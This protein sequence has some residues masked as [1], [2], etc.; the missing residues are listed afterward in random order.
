MNAERIGKKEKNNPGQNLTYTHT[1]PL[2]RQ[3]CVH[4]DMTELAVTEGKGSS[5]R[6]KSMLVQRKRK[7]KERTQFFV[8]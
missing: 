6:K 1:F 7:Q 5:G 4:F 3:T 2:V 8:R